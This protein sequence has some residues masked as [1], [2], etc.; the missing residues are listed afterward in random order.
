M[1]CKTL[2][3]LT[4]LGILT[5]MPSI[6]YAKAEKDSLILDRVYAYPL[7]HKPTNDTIQNHVYTKTFYNV[8]RRNPILWLIPT[9][10]V[11]ADGDR[12]CIRESYK[13]ANIINGHDIDVKQEV[14][15]GTIRSNRRAIPTLS[16]LITPRIYDE[17]MFN[18]H[19]LSPFNRSNKR[20]YRYTQTTNANGT[21]R[22]DFVP[23]HF[24][25]QLLSGY[26]I[27]E[28]ETGR[29]LRAVL[30]GEYDMITF[31][32]EIMYS[33]K[34]G[35]FLEPW[36]SSTAATFKFMG[37]RI[38]TVF[39][40]YYN[41]PAVIND[42]I[43]GASGRAAMDTLRPVPL[44]VHE[45]ELYEAKEM[46]EES[47]AKADTVPE[48]PNLLKKIFW[49]TIGETLVTPIEAESKQVYF[50][51]SPI[52]NPLY[53]SYSDTKGFSYKMALGFQYIFSQYRY[54]TLDPS[55]GYNFKIRQF[56][57]DVP[58]R[59]TY[60]PK[61]N[62]YAEIIFANGNRSGSSS[63]EQ[64]VREKLGIP[65]SVVFEDRDQH[66]FKDTYL[67][68]FNN[69]MLFDWI[70]IESGFIFHRRSA[71]NKEWMR[72]YDMPTDYRSF[73]PMIGLKIRPWYEG[74][75]FSI[76]WQRGING[77]AKSNIDYELVEIDASWKR[78][79]SY[80]R[81]LN[82]RA[83]FGAY[84]RKAQNYFVDYA[85]FQDTNLPEGWDDDWSGDFQLLDG[86]EYNRSN[87]YF[88][89]NAS[90]ESPLLIATRLPYLGKYIEKERIYFSSVLLERSRPYIEIG[91]GFT[92]RYI[93]AAA[94]ASF[95]NTT[96]MDIG[97]KFDFELFRRW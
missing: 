82:L 26:A 24:N 33:S 71:V 30:N 80:L 31:R 35:R 45:E 9:M 63:V 60:N 58:L 88:R 90:Y 42:S 84:T 86:D 15:S 25:T 50:E 12:E 7:Y 32:T 96:F 77:V 67:R 41:C 21:T 3:N 23:K 44:T 78:K 64:T 1:K 5:C 97:F 93:S 89:A 2:I 76:D 39:S 22:I 94:F 83:G 49:D 28:T 52:I 48:K 6:I 91:Y 57:F 92:N 66:K 54:L 75:L 8:E 70:D 51:L 56:Y 68:V 17:A 73:A 19:I 29:I 69:I 11:L 55:F 62:G 74:P 87:Y 46:K 18:R 20:F 53:V 79:L 37:N 14:V 13:N 27:I 40:S 16:E 34:G 65:D 4:V 95:R 81:L 59:M 38:S 47:E 72:Q 10:Y 61:R 43:R 36:R 85:N